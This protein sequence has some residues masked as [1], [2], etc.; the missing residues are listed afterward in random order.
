[1][2]VGGLTASMLLNSCYFNSAGHIFDKASYNAGAFTTDLRPDG[3]QMVYVDGDDYYIELPRYRMG[4][5]VKTQYSVF[6]DEEEVVEHSP[7][8]KNETDM[9]QIPRDFAMYLTGRASGP[10]TPSYM[11]RVENGG[12]I[13]YGSD[14]SMPIVKQAG[15]YSETFRYRSPNAAWLYTAGVFDWLC[16]DL[17]VTCVENALVAALFTV[18]FAGAMQ[19]EANSY[20]YDSYSS[21]SSGLC[22][23]CQGNGVSGGWPCNECGGKKVPGIAY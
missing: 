13:K 16:V 3:R 6:D 22:P 21:G 9:Y 11:T 12:W 1:M 19:S 23:K 5:P 8:L 4:A 17:P 10:S 2:V 20:S 15:N 7:Q 18:V 14:T